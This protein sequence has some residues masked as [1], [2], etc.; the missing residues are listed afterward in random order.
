MENWIS[1]LTEN[2]V[3]IS[4]DE[5]FVEAS[6]AT[7]GA[8][9]PLLHQSLLSVD[10]P[11]TDKFLQGQLCCDV[12]LARETGSLLGAHCNVK[13]HMISLFR[14]IA[15][16]SGFLLRLHRDILAPAATTLKK[17]IIF[18]KAEVTNANE[19]LVGIGLQG[20]QAEAL[21]KCAADVIPAEVN[22]AT[23]NGN[24][25]LVRVPGD[26]FEL[27]L[28]DTDA[29]GLLPSL[30][31]IGALGSTNDW[32]LSEIQAGIP[33]LRAET[34]EAFIPQMTN[35]QALDGVSFKKGC[36]TGQEIITRLQHRGQL[37]RPMYRLQVHTQNCPAPGSTLHSSERE[38]IGKVVIAAQSSPDSCEV[39]AVLIKDIADTGDIHL[40]SMTGPLASVEAL[41]YTL[42][43]A[44]FEP[45]T[46]L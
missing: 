21:A 19:N 11:D 33:D 22:Q 20:E 29:I 32:L 23:V 44:M 6:A 2:G 35:F 43:P 7:A 36:Y 5:H 45:K 31:K 39:L 1:T 8:V 30:L 14:L 13:G 37:K 24:R 12:E 25:Y 40:E 4:Q 46:R 41:P 15:T 42:D 18:S 28:P 34:S 27:W 10:G 38:N 3:T 16:D 9:I 26:R 17:Y